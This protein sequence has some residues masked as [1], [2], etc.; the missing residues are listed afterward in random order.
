M[1]QK[2]FDS[3]LRQI[4]AKLSGR[5]WFLNEYSVVDPYLFV[6]YVWGARRGYPMHELKNFKDL[7]YNLLKRQAVQ[8]LLSKEGIKL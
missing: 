2:T 3:Y 6:F 8:Q 5:Q 7:K 4:D 1:G